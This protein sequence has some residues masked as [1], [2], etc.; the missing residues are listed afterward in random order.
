MPGLVL[1]LATPGWRWTLLDAMTKRTAF[2]ADAVARLGL[3]DRVE[4]TTRRAEE[5]GRSGDRRGHFDAV[6]ARGFGPPPVTAEC[7][8]PLLRVGGVLLVSEP[9]GSKGDR[10]DQTAL[11]ELGL[12]F[13]GVVVA[14]PALGRLRQVEPCPERFPRRTGVPVKRPLWRST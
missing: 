1:A 13:E 10:W 7:G 9:P 8:A 12:R 6:T 2:L 4:V 3:V 11:R 14:A 5:L